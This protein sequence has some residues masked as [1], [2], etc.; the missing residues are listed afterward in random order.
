MAVASWRRRDTACRFGAATITHQT[1]GRRRRSPSWPRPLLQ[2]LVEEAPAAGLVRQPPG[3]LDQRP[4]Q[5]PRAGLGDP[6]VL[7]AVVA[8][9]DSGARPA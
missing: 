3:G 9:A 2:P 6:Q 8:L 7:G 1:G 4:S 5:Q